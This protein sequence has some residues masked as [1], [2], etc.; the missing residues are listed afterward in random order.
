MKKQLNQNKILILFLSWRLSLFIAAFIGG[1]AWAFQGSFPYFQQE[2]IITG[3]PNWLW[4]FGNFDGVHYLRIAEYS[5]S[6]NFTQVFFPVFPILIKSFSFI[7]TFWSGLII[8]NLA[9]LG[10]LGILFRLWKLDF[11]EKVSLKSLLF[12]MAFPTAFYFGAIYTESIFLLWVVACI[13]SLRT[14]HLIW[15]GLFGALASGTRVLGVLLFVVILIEAW[16][17]IQKLNLKAILALLLAPL[18]LIIYMAYLGLQF[19]NPLYFLTAQVA[20]GADRN[21]T[22]FVL[23]PQVLFRYLKILFFSGNTLE[24]FLRALFE[25][26]ST[27]VAFVPLILLFRKVRLSYLLFSFGCLIIPTFTGT[28][29]SMPRYILMGF[30]II[31]YLVTGLG[32]YYKVAITLMWIFQLILVSLFVRGY[33]IA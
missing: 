24:T 28:L 15:A 29:S 19:K 12:L 2:L 4:G 32:R 7:S 27:L 21:A 8:S 18:G 23:L 3:L 14:N 16:P 6:L 5:Y 13:Y 9:F 20:F 11:S 33:F 30:L 31:P 26:I 22:K 17:K 25:L 10:A 1:I